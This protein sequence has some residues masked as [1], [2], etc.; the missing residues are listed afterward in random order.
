MTNVRVADIMA[1]MNQRYPID[2]AEE[3]DSVGLVVGNV[4]AHVTKV[5]FA[6][7]PVLEVVQEA[8]AIGA[9]C[10]IAHHPLLLRGVNT[11]AGNTSKGQV[12]Q[13]LIK[14]D[15]ALYTAHTNADVAWP[16]VSD[17]IAQA[18]GVTVDQG[19]SLSATGIGRTGALSE[20]MTLADFVDLVGRVIGQTAGGIQVA[21][22]REAT[23]RRVAICGGAGDSLLAEVATLDVDVYV[24]SDLRHHV[25]QDFRQASDIALVNVSHWAAESMWLPQ[26]AK[27][28]VQDMGGNVEVTVSKVTTNPWSFSQ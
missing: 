8:V 28:L 6:I 18:L 24:T 13:A 15:I 25:T 26:A 16:G 19:V 14:H 21:G 12:I 10:I 22:D 11:V 17:A 9:N 23:V 3:W 4:D 27:L 20:P 5:L 7:D 2:S 1:T